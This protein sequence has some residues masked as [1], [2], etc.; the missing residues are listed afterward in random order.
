[1]TNQP[2]PPGADR[3]SPA[4]KVEP[5]AGRGSSPDTAADRRDRRRRGIRKA[6]ALEYQRGKQRAPVVTAAGRGEMAEQIIALAQKHGIYVQP[7]P[8]LVEVLAQLDLGTAIPPQ[9]YYV[10][11]EILA[12]V[13]KLNNAQASGQT[14]L[15]VSNSHAQDVRS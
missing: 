8:D 4:D 5:S 7:D 10:V 12:F 6:V 15:A 11:A 13:Y 9:L 1:V 2:L 14:S 3:V